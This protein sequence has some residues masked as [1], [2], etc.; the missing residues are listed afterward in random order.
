VLGTDQL[1]LFLEL[2]DLV[3]LVVVASPVPY[4]VGLCRILDLCKL[5]LKVFFLG[6][7]VVHFRLLCEYFFAVFVEDLD[8]AFFEV[9]ST[10]VLVFDVHDHEAAIFAC[11]EEVPVVIA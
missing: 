7:V 1:D 6:F 11:R 5:S 9:T 10:G 2:C 8:F 3:F 4:C